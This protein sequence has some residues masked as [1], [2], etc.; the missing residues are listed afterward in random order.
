M[1]DICGP[2]CGET[3]C[4]PVAGAASNNGNGEREVVFDRPE[5]MTD[6]VMHY[7]PGCT[8]GIIHRLVGEMIDEFGLFERTVGVC[9]VGCS[10]FAFE[11]FHFDMIEAS[12]GRAAAVATAVKRADPNR[13]VF[14]YQGDGDLAAIGL[15]ESVH[16]A[17]RGE[18]ICVF[19]VNNGIYGMTGGQMAPTSLVGQKTTT[20]P[21]GRELGIAGPPIGVCEMLSSLPAVAYLA[22]V[23]IT[24]PKNIHTARKY[25]RAAIRAQLEHKGFALVEF[26]ST[27]PV[28]WGMSPVKAME[29]IDKTVVQTFKPGVFIDR[30]TPSKEPIAQAI[31]G[32]VATP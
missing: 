7:C 4:T 2:T 24:S 10:V 30:V 6:K 17:A 32:M 14:T 11:Y 21:R 23:P 31:E 18:N 5:C 19:F 15:A 13:F 27:C 1:G 28:Q 12:H 29:Y 25:M 8:H 3:A 9:P 20:S 26:L 22:R 16:A